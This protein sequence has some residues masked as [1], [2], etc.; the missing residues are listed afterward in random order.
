M[1]GSELIYEKSYQ[2]LCQTESQIY[3]GL[4]GHVILYALRINLLRK[5]PTLASQ[6]VKERIL[7]VNHMTWLKLRRFLCAENKLLRKQ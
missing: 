4:L 7:I 5:I 2:Y 1:E 3:G 6:H